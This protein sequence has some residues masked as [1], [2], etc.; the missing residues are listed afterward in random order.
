MF[1]LEKSAKLWWKNHS[2]RTGVDQTTITWEYPKEQLKENYQNCTYQVERLN[3]FLDCSSQGNWDIRSFYQQF[4][5][6]LK[7]APTGMLQHT[8]VAQFVSRLNSPLKERLQSLRLTTF[9]DVLDA[10]RPIEQ[11]LNQAKKKSVATRTVQQNSLG[12]PEFK[13]PAPQ[14]RVPT[15][16]PSL[17]I[18]ANQE[19]LCYNCFEP[20][21]CCKDCPILNNDQQPSEQQSSMF[22]NQSRS[23]NSSGT[24]YSRPPT[25]PNRQAQPQPKQRGIQR[26]MIHNNN[27]G[28]RA[29]LNPQ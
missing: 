26:P 8:K 12:R 6:L 11:E 2:L 21:H 7:Y 5:K 25:Y 4:L 23:Q 20:D 1:K 3:E 15:L 14:P 29:N 18:K 17:K 16:S 22:Y 24:N 27:Q 13:R 9:I 28:N 10:G 19:N